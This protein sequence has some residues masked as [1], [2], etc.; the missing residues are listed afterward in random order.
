MAAAAVLS[1]AD[2]SMT[3]TFAVG[4]DPTVRIDSYRGRVTVLQ[5]TSG[6]VVVDVRYNVPT[7]SEDKAEKAFQTVKFTW[8]ASAAGV[9]L[10]V[11]DPQQTRAWFDWEK[12]IRVDYVY[13]VTVPAGAHVEIVVGDGSTEIG[14]MTGSVTAN[15]NH[16]SIVVRQLKGSIRAR[17]GEGDCVVSRCSG[18]A[19]IDNRS[20]AVQIGTVGG[21][22]TIRNANGGVE[23][24]HALGSAIVSAVSGDVSLGLPQRVGGEVRVDVDGGNLYL[25][26]DPAA[27]CSVDASSIWGK[28]RSDFPFV[29]RSGGLGKRRLDGTLNGGGPLLVLHANGGN[30]KI[31]PLVEPRP[32]GSGRAKRLAS[33]L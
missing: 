9:A 24:Q 7:L 19:D 12:D 27:A 33:S 30:V 15:V 18:D 28:V 10:T 20:G 26:I 6:Q 14:N 1:A 16:G 13:K 4:A 5:G 23:L 8:D 17:L 29:V 25:K 11:R 22:A 32:T 31:G 21:R 2:R 3:K